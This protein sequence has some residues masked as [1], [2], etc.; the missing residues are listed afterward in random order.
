VARI[1]KD[2]KYRGRKNRY[3]RQIDAEDHIAG[4]GIDSDDE[5][6]K[7]N[8]KNRSEYLDAIKEEDELLKDPHIEE[9]EIIEA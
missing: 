8:Y 5:G 9:E 6:S 3:F 4:V 7:A 1:K 2:K